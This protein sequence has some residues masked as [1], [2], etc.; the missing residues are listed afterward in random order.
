VGKLNVTPTWKNFGIGPAAKIVKSRHR[1]RDDLRSL[2]P[3]KRTSFGTVAMSAL[4]HKRTS[5]TGVAWRGRLLPSTEL[6]P[7]PSPI[8]RAAGAVRPR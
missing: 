7:T 6:P 4:C 3:Q 2:Y 5:G 8:P 1:R